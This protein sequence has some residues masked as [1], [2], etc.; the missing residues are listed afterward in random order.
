[1]KN[2]LLIEDDL[3]IC[4][5]IEI[6]IREENF[7][8]ESVNNGKEGIERVMKNDY[9]LVIVDL[10]LPVISGEDVCKEIRKIS[11]V[12]IIVISAKDSIASKLNLFD[13]GAD[14]Y[15]TKPFSLEELVGRIKVM[16]RNKGE[17]S[18]GTF[19]NYSIIKIDRSE[20][21][22][23]VKEREVK[24]SKTEYDLLYY[25][26]IN[27]EI[28]V[29]RETLLTKIW[30]YDYAGN[31]KIVDVYISYLRNKIE[32]NG[33]KLIHTVRGTGYILKEQK[34]IEKNIK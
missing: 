13:I 16:F 19:I 25:L 30:G 27:R 21:K 32:T 20:N 18:T 33:I 14:D 15:L 12:P 3:K 10:M 22:V 17:Y 26:L 7:F 2:I 28:V 5:L 31:E 23:F 24:L 34:E 9:N 4:R 29:S 6:R 8:I 1:M 11:K